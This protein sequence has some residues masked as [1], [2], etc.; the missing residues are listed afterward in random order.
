MAMTAQRAGENRIVFSLPALSI[1]SRMMERIFA[2]G[3]D[4]PVAL[5]DGAH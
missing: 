1:S 2:S 5:T 4:L 3:I